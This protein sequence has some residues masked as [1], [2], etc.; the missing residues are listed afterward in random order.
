MKDT[1]KQLSDSF[2]FIKPM[3]ATVTSISLFANTHIILQDLAII[4]SI[5][6][7]IYKLYKLNQNTDEK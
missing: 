3:G 4:L 1:L 2:D 6:Y 5:A 7:T